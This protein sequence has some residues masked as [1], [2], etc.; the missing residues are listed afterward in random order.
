[1]IFLVQSFTKFVYQ[2]AKGLFSF[3][4][5]LSSVVEPDQPAKTDLDFVEASLKGTSYHLLSSLFIHQIQKGNTNISVSSLMT[6]QMSRHLSLVLLL[7]FFGLNGC[8][9]L[10]VGELPPKERN[11]PS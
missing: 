1:M 3:K 4:T 11:R 5:V 2:I 10:K 8:F 9:E 6:L 7:T